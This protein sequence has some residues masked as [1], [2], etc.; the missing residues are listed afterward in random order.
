MSRGLGYIERAIVN[1]LNKMKDSE[2]GLSSEPIAREI[3]AHGSRRGWKP[4]VAQR[5]ACVRAMHSLHTKFGNPLKGGRGREPLSIDLRVFILGRG[6]V[7][8][9]EA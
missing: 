9:P 1:Q 7:G 2:L 8:E 6:I 3:F 4:T 5:K